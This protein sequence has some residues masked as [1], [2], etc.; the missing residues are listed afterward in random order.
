M[1]R[2]ASLPAG[3]FCMFDVCVVPPG[4]LHQRVLQLDVP[5]ILLTFFLLKAVVFARLWVRPTF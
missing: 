2:P 4:L 1:S 3:G 5:L